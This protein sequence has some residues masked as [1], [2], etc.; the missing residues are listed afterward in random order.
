MHSITGVPQGS[1]ISPLLS[2]IYLHEFD[3]FME[4]IK[5]EYTQEGVISRTRDEYSKI[6][7]K[8]LKGRN[9]LKKLLLEKTEAK[10]ETKILLCKEKIRKAKAELKEYT[11]IKRATPSKEKIL[12]RVY[13]LRYADD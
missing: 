12:T 7:Y 13:Y 5:S 11:A 4:R 1:V 3:K 9:I 8:E 6:A 2:N 10:S